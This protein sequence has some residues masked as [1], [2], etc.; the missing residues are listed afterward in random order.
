MV[1][2]I[3]HSYTVFSLSELPG[4]D[5]SLMGKN[6]FGVLVA[7]KDIFSVVLQIFTL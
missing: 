2:Y 5:L 7:R 6:G 4:S 1:D 3:E